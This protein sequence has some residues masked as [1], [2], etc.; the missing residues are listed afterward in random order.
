MS[1]AAVLIDI[2]FPNPIEGIPKI[3]VTEYAR[4]PIIG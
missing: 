2:I 1:P 4:I 3:I